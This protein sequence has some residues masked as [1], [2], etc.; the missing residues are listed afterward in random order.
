MGYLGLSCLSLVVEV[1][2]LSLVV[3]WLSSEDVVLS[4]ESSDP[5]GSESV[6]GKVAGELR[7]DSLI[8]SAGADSHSDAVSLVLGWLM[9]LRCAITSSKVGGVVVC[10]GGLV[11]N[12][13][14]GAGIGLGVG[15]L[16][17]VGL[18]CGDANG[19]E[20]IVCWCSDVD[21]PEILALCCSDIDGLEMV[22]FRC[23]DVDGPVMVVFCCSDIGSPEMLYFGA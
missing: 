2:E 9:A 4:V 17:M 23:L 11:R 19:L 20:M 5:P 18:C 6:V 1:K 21:G 13:L 12:F 8:W 10:C 15:G 14:H 16:E 7:F 3:D 22:V